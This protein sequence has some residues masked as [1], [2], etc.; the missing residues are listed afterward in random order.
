MGAIHREGKKRHTSLR[1]SRI[2]LTGLK[3]F[4]MPC[5]RC[6]FRTATLSL[7]PGKL[8]LTP[9]P[10]FA[11]ALTPGQERS[12]LTGKGIPVIREQHSTIDT[13]DQT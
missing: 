6:R 7:T 5:E 9:F 12:T 2:L 8:T 11:I 1:L 4:F 13:G 3:V 10:R